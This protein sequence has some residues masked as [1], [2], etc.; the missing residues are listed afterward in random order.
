MRTIILYIEPFLLSVSLVSHLFLLVSILLA[1]QV[2]KRRW[3]CQC[4]SKQITPVHYEAHG[5]DAL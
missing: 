5:S 4:S 1:T 3:N 2:A